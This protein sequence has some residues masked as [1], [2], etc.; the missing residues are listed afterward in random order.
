[1]P[2]R[3]TLLMR[4]SLAPSPPPSRE[5]V[6][7]LNT[8]LAVKIPYRDEPTYDHDMLA[9][10]DDGREAVR[11]WTEPHDPVVL[12]FEGVDVA[13]P[14]FL[15]EIH[16]AWPAARPENMSDD[17]TRAW[18]MVMER[19]RTNPA[20]DQSAPMPPKQGQ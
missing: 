17:V 11:R 7:R 20:L 4:R 12:D 16:K 18:A 6:D 15:D 13:S 14:T 3:T 2:D 19:S 5:T 1:M 8:V 10:R 9:T